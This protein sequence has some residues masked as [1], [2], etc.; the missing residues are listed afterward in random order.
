MKK[1]NS[2]SCLEYI[3]SPLSN[4]VIQTAAKAY[5]IIKSNQTVTQR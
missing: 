2:D 5:Q 1:N 4:N 3:S